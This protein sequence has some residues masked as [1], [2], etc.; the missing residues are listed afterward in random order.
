MD[1]KAAEL[2]GYSLNG[3][4]GE[5]FGFGFGATDEKFEFG[6]GELQRENVQ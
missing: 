2:V 6:F 1:A 4:V 3:R 5:G